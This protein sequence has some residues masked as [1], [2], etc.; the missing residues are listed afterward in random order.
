MLRVNTLPEAVALVYPE[1]PVAAWFFEQLG[2]NNCAVAAYLIEHACAVRQRVQINVAHSVIVG[3]WIGIH[4]QLI[5][6]FSQC[7]RAFQC[8]PIRISFDACLYILENRY[9]LHCGLECKTDTG[10]P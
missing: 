8:Y 2:F 9:C 10:F 7:T 5:F 1:L 4:M 6:D 3:Y